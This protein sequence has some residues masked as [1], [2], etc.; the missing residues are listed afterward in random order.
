LRHLGGHPPSAPG[1]HLL[2]KN[3]GL[4]GRRIIGEDGREIGT[5]GDVVV[6][7]EPKAVWGFEVSDGILMDLLDGRSVIEA[8]GAQLYGDAV[9]LTD[10][11]YMNFGTSGHPTFEG[12]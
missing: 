4:C 5:I 11:D 8:R 2:A 10:Q 12:S 3:D 1:L 7:D 6:T 9:M